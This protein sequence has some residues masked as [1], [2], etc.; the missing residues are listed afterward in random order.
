MEPLI[1]QGKQ[2]IMMLHSA[3][4]FLGA[5]AIRGLSCEARKKEGK[6]GGVVKLV[7][8]AGAVWK[9]RHHQGPLP[10]FGYQVSEAEH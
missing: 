1:D 7:F 5:M 4:G 10:I 3:G 8:L 6:D 2:V 9:E